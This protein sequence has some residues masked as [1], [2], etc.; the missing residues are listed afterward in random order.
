MN[1]FNFFKNINYLLD[2]RSRVKFYFIFVAMIIGSILK[3]GN[4]NKIEETYDDFF[5]VII[6][7]E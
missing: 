7:H 2:N 3:L 6:R 1:V 4:L 5:Q